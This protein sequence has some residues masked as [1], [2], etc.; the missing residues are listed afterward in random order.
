MAFHHNIQVFLYIYLRNIIYKYYVFVLSRNTI[1][2]HRPTAKSY[3]TKHSI[4]LTCA[5]IAD[6]RS[7][8]VIIVKN[9]TVSTLLCS[10]VVI[11][12]LLYNSKK[13]HCKFLQQ[14][15]CTVFLIQ[16]GMHK[17]SN[18]DFL[19][20]ISNAISTTLKCKPR[21]FCNSVLYDSHKYN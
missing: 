8:C 16:N 2:A 9:Y 13:L 14:F 4:T 19:L 5:L 6:Y 7:S 10:W 18:Y 12:M 11:Y 3:F 17:N 20:D 21:E 1:N 15:F